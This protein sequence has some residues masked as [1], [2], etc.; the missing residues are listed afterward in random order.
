MSEINQPCQGEGP[1]R[2]WR[3]VAAGVLVAGRM[4]FTDRGFVGTIRRGPVGGPFFPQ[5]D[6]R[7]LVDEAVEYPVQVNGK[8]RSHI[9]VEADT[10]AAAVEAAALADEK[11]SA[12]FAEMNVSETAS[13]YPSA[14][15]VERSL[16]SRTASGCSIT[17]PANAGSVFLKLS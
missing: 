10:D 3:R 5:P 11:F 4:T 14:S 8:V 1:L 9:S 6:E 13:L 17:A 7:Y 2:R 15:E 12:S 16:A